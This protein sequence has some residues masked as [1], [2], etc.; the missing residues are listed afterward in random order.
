MQA[1]AAGLGGGG[2]GGRGLRRPRPARPCCPRS[3]RPSSASPRRAARLPPS[4]APPRRLR[5]RHVSPSRFYWKSAS[6]LSPRFG[7]NGDTSAPSSELT[8]L[9][10]PLL[11]EEAAE[12]QTGPGGP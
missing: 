8:Q 12:E 3:A 10:V 1:G 6:V 2:R 5:N 7:S 4:R 9:A 11:A